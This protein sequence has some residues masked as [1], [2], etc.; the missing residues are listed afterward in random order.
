MLINNNGSIVRGV[1]STGGPSQSSDYAADLGAPPLH[2][3][4]SSRPSDRITRRSVR[5]EGGLSSPPAFVEDSYY[6]V[7]SSP[8]AFVEGPLINISNFQIN[9]NKLFFTKVI[10]F[11]LII[12]FYF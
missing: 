5:Q 12:I 7:A 8:T 10:D 11:T 9:F 6:V 1:S 3:A 4:R 2:V